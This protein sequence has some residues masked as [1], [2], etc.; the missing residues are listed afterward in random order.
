MGGVVNR[1]NNVVRE[2]VLGGGRGGRRE[3]KDPVVLDQHCHWY[4]G[5]LYMVRFR[6]GRCC[7]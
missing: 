7:L 4:Q 5:I 3:E 6:L 1:V 2:E